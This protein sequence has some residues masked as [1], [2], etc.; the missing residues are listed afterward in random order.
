MG[1]NEISNIASSETV[2]AILFIGL[3]FLVGK[4][5]KQFIEKQREDSNKREE[6]IFSMHER[7]QEESKLREEKL[8]S[9]LS[10]NTDQLEKIA[11]T[12]D[13]LETRVEHNFSEVWKEINNK[14]DKGRDE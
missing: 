7:Q 11:G 10:R 1:V 4:F 2:F 3:L 8:H 13:K 9:H 14:Q 6:Y 12:L 5:I